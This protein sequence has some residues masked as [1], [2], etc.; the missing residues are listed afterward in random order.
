MCELGGGLH[1]YHDGFLEMYS[2][3][4]RSA[5]HGREGTEIKEETNTFKCV[6]HFQRRENSADTNLVPFIGFFFFFKYALIQNSHTCNSCP[7]RTRTSLRTAHEA[8]LFVG[9]C[10]HRPSELVESK[11]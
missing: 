5:G 3:Y 9:S 2:F 11:N 8:G 10:L 4:Q 1:P 7:T 6:S